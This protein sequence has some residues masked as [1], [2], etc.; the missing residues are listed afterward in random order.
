MTCGPLIIW[1]G[2]V[3]NIYERVIY[4]VTGERLELDYDLNESKLDLPEDE[5]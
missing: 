3:T 2:R 1:N 4:F 5:W